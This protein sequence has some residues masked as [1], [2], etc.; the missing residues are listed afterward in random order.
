MSLFF[1]D[2]ETPVFASVSVIILS[3]HIHTHVY[4]HIYMHKHR[5]I[6]AVWCTL[7]C[8]APSPLAWN[9]SMACWLYSPASISMVGRVA[10]PRVLLLC[11][12]GK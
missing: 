2:P 12:L 3:A 8:A 11:I 1:L 7:A 5:H 9:S 6:H 4:V 10:W